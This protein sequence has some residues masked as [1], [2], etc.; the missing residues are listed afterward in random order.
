MKGSTEFLKLIL[1]SVTEHIVVIDESG[2][3][4]FVNKSWD[5]FG[6]NN[7]CLMGA[8]WTEANYIK[9]CDKAAA[10]GDEY[11]VHAGSGIRQVI[12]G[13]EPMFYFEY[14]CHSPDEKRWFMM[15]V[16]P[17]E[18]EGSNYFVISH[19]N[20]TE[21]KIIE[22][23][24]EELARLDGLTQIPNRR[25]F[26]TFLDSEWRRCIRLNKTLSLALVD[27]D[28]FKLLNDT[29]GHQL[30]D[31]ALVRVATVLKEFAHRPGDV[32]ARYGGEEFVMIWGD[33]SLEQAKIM[34]KKLL[35]KITELNI[36]NR[37]SPTYKTLT[38]SLGLA[39]MTP[40]KGCNQ[41]EIVARADKLLYKAKENGRNRVE[42]D[43]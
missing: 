7:A 36:E 23:K 17:F 6:E 39:A 20:I 3:I 33:T 12:N 4:Q 19:Q 31:E 1:D 14:P 34:A 10:M 35:K 28:H 42:F 27:L 25:T 22:E 5:S 8:D 32:C 37:N 30:G 11:G 38:A 16:T 15:R 13:Q 26:D 9:E 29:Y 2:K 43:W 18:T 24:V 40:T 21:R 41:M